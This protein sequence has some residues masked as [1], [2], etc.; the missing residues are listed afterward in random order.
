MNSDLA[1]NYLA[2]A[3]DCEGMCFSDYLLNV[4]LK[5]ISSD[6]WKV[7]F[8]QNST[9]IDQIVKVSVAKQLVIGLAAKKLNDKTLYLDPKEVQSAWE[10]L[11]AVG[12]DTPRG[13]M[14]WNLILEPDNV[15]DPS[16]MAYGFNQILHVRDDF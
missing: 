4:Y 3:V 12:M 16:N 8:S 2:Y 7:N 10:E 15:T 11:Q 14:F 13:L 6:S 5:N 9:L 1:Y